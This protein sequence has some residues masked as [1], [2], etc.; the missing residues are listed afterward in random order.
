MIHALIA[1][2]IFAAWWSWATVE[3]ASIATFIVTTAILFLPIFGFRLIIDVGGEL[4][5]EERR[6]RRVA[7]MDD[8]GPGS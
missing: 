2:L 6:R 3:G 7:G 1:S 4:L 5:A 8:A